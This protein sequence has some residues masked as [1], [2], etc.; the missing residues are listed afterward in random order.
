MGPHAEK[1]K[2]KDRESRVMAL[3]FCLDFCRSNHGESNVGRNDGDTVQ[4][5]I[6]D[7]L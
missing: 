6:I 2:K 1:G 7:V 3:D 4:Y 5:T